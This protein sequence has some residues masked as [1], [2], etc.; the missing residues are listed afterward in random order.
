[1]A[2]IAGEHHADGDFLRYRPACSAVNGYEEEL[3]DDRAKN[4]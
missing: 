2:I 3:E 1:M 4:G